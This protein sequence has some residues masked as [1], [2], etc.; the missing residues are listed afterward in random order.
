MRTHI[1]LASSPAKAGDPV[2]RGLSAPALASLEYWIVRSSRTMTAESC[3]KIESEVS[4]RHCEEHLR[5]SNPSL[6]ACRTMDCFVTLA[7]TLREPAQA[8]AAKVSRKLP[9]AAQPQTL[10]RFE[11]DHG[12]QIPEDLELV[13]LGQ[14]AQIGNGLGD[15]GHGLIRAALPIGLLCARSAIPARSCALPAAPSLAQ[16]ITSNAA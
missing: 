4:P 3:L 16:K 2:R 15:E 1:H 5:R 8:R 9:L 14:F 13:A 12:K 10:F 11:L 6:L 7:M